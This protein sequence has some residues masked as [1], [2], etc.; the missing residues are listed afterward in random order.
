MKN[1]CDAQYIILDAQYIVQC[2]AIL[3]TIWV[4]QSWQEKNR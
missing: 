1:V 2:V 3:R 4:L